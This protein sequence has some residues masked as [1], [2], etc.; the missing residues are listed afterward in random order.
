MCIANSIATVCAAI[1]ADV[2]LIESTLPWTLAEKG[3][4]LTVNLDYT[5]NGNDS[6]SACSCEPQINLNNSCYSLD[7][8]PLC[9]NCMCITCTRHHRTYLHHLLTV[10]EMN[11]TILLVIHNLAWLAELLRCCRRC[12]NRNERTHLLRHVLSQY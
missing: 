5:H 4:A 2:H 6:T 10:Q 9:T 1:D 7:T 11:A 8:A 12:S 3:I